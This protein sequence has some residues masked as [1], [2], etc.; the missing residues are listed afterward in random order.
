M[1]SKHIPS[2][3][4][5]SLLLT[6]FSIHHL[7]AQVG[8]RRSDFSVG[9]TAGVLLNKV[10]F[11]PKVKQSM[12]MSPM[13][14]FACRYICEKYFT[15][16]AGI[17][18]EVNYN[19]LGWQELIEDG[20]GNTFSRNLS[21]IQVPILM[22]MG[23]GREVRG[24]KFVFNAGPQFGYYLGSS[25]KRGGGEWN[26]TNRPNHVTY[27]YSHGVDNKFDYGI[28]AGLGVEFSSKVGHI[29]I[30]GRYYYGLG[31]FY[32]NSKKGY[33]GRSANQTIYAKL[34]YLFDMV[35]TKNCVRK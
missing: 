21:Y 24:F 31:D 9:G 15:C 14:G 30:E 19:N 20:S 7:S 35:K 22:Q 26:T 18:A 27:Q 12:K 4:L 25:E 33:F 1:S 23:W 3:I 5:L 10:D 13:F 8:E 28:A 17:Q 2:R 32:D 29:I 6:L 11:Y 16:I 34:T